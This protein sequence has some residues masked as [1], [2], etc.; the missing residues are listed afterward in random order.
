MTGNEALEKIKQGKKIRKIKWPEDRYLFLEDGVVKK[1]WTWDGIPKISIN[2]GYITDL[3][4]DDWEL[5][6]KLRD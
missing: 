6:D 2:A 4:E 5:F 1:Y 3:L